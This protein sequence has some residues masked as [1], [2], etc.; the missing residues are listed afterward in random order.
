MKR[1]AAGV[2]RG[3][4]STGV[5]VG[6]MTDVAADVVSIIAGKL[7]NE[8]PQI[9]LTDKLEDLGL[10]SLDAVEMIFE[11]EEKFDITIPY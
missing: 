1:V 3:R 10:E 8:R 5:R 4:E 2:Y 9:E 7:R 6:R 11:L